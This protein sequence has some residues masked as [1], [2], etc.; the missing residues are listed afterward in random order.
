MKFKSDD[1]GHVF[2]LFLLLLLLFFFFFFIYLLALIL[3]R[4]TTIL[5]FIFT[6]DNGKIK[7]AMFDS[8]S[9]L[10]MEATTFNTGTEN[11]NLINLTAIS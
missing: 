5:W 3:F 1:T 10:N 9:W 4:K 7:T 2:L 11:I 6:D 8:L